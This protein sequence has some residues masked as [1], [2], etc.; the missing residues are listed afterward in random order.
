MFEG[1]PWGGSLVGEG[2]RGPTN[3]TV[4]VLAAGN[5]N[6]RQGICRST[7]MYCDKEDLG[8]GRPWGACTLA[9]LLVAAPDGLPVDRMAGY[10]HIYT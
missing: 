4:P 10:W 1:H 5:K 7:A 8:E 9:R 3:A 2:Q 6:D